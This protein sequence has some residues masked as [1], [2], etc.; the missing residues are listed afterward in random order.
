MT[1]DPEVFNQIRALLS[2]LFDFPEDQLQP[3]THLRQ[4]LDL[5][6]IDVVAIINRIHE[7]TGHRIEPAIF[8]ELHTIADVAIKFKH[9][10]L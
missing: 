8:R 9:I 1:P 2:E 5:D 6:S 7:N 3:D 4:D 10:L